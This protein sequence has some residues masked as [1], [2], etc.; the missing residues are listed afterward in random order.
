MELGAYKKIPNL[1]LKNG[2]RYHAFREG[3]Y[4]LVSSYNPSVT[5]PRNPL[6]SRQPNDEQ[7]QDRMDLV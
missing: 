7:E 6:T 1:S 2:R 5:E 3:S 4:M